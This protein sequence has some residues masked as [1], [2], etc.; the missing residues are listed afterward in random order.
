MVKAILG[1]AVA[2]VA[3]LSAGVG[4]AAPDLPTDHRIIVR[5]DAKGE[6]RIAVTVRGEGPLV[7]LIPSLGRGAA[8]F[9][10]LAGRLAAAGYRAAAIDPRGV[11]DSAGPMTG[12]TLGDYAADV[13]AVVATLSPG[14]P[15]VLIGHAFGNRVARATA[16]SHPESVSTLVLLAAGGQVAP[17]PDISRALMDVFDT[18]LSP[19]DH[20]AAV[21]KA[22]FA[23]GADPTPWLGG[24]Y[25]AVM[26]AQRAA[27]AATGPETWRGAGEAPILIVQADEDVIAPPANAEALAKAYPDRV[28]VMRLPRAGHAML[29]EQP[30][31]VARLVIRFL[32]HRP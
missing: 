2:L 21:A 14:K 19:A 7:V 11:G 8:D 23:P 24:W 10:D 26:R 4:M 31:E 25:P 13:A 1:W 20:R 32:G 12:L 5:A 15:A 17:S 16:A 29:P 27:V 30:L 22:F 6:A 28:T 18:A 9:D 3:C